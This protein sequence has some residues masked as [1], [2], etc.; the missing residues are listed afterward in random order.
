MRHDPSERRV[1]VR[2][3]CL[4]LAVLAGCELDPPT[5][6]AEVRAAVTQANGRLASPDYWWS[7]PPAA[8]ARAADF[9]RLWAACGAE[10][11]VRLLQVDRE[12]YR[13]GLLSTVPTITKQVF[14]PWRTDAVTLHDGVESTLGTV[15]RTVR[16]EVRRRDDGQ[17]EVVPKVLVERY[18]SAERRLTAISQ[19]HQAF[20]GPRAF[21]DSPDLTGDVTAENAVADYWYPLR[22]DAALERDLAASIARRVGG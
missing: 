13:D 15:R 9:D 21:A 3:F 11:Y 12:D 6:S 7:Q 1:Y 8:R 14:E 5:H 10:A 4:T 18:A 20:S 16:F 19:Y 2:G 17:F 22:R